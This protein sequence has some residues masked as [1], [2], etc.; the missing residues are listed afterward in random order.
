MRCC[1]ILHYPC[2]L[3]PQDCWIFSN[4]IIL[5][6]TTHDE[7]FNLSNK[8]C[9]IL[10]HFYSFKVEELK[11]PNFCM[12]LFLIVIFSKNMMMHSIRSL[13][14]II[15]LWCNFVALIIYKYFWFYIIHQLYPPLLSKCTLSTWT[16]PIPVS[17][18]DLLM[19]CRMFVIAAFW[20]H[21]VGSQCWFISIEVKYKITS[22][23]LLKIHWRLNHLYYSLDKCGCLISAMIQAMGAQA[24]V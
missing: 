8:P 24:T 9:G 22:N 11:L 23:N 12:N 1:K 2:I 16:F 21:V 19:E 7:Q 4:P 10:S 17:G 20:G 13:L 15:F 14:D 18:L 6:F 3:L 5:H